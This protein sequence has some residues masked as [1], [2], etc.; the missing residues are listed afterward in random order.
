VNRLMAMAFIGALCM[1]ALTACGGDDD[2]SGSASDLQEAN[3]AYCQDLT[4]Y[5][6]ALKALVAL[7]PTAT[8]AQYEDAAEAAK[9]ARE[10][11][12]SS[13]EKLGEE[14]VQNLQTQVDELKDQLKDA[15]DEK[16]AASI[17]AAAQPQAIK[18]QASAAAVNTAVCT[19]GNATTTT[20]A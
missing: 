3:A 16:S 13:A 19:P 14:G 7:G 2:D 6:S 4:A 8:K 11:L 5:A 12:A 10:D 18:V 20:K 17:L 1:A 9:D 15:P